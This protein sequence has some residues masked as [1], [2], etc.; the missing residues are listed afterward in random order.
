MT[1][2]QT[3]DATEHPRRATRFLG[4]LP[5]VAAVLPPFWPI[6][7]ILVGLGWLVMMT[8]RDRMEAALVSALATAAAFLALRASVS[9][10]GMG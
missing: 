6:F 9:I 10:F 3:S 7:L 1:E 2:Q 8:T 5:F 4:Y